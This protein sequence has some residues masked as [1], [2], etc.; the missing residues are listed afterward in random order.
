MQDFVVQPLG[1]LVGV[2]MYYLFIF[3]QIV[4]EALP[5]SSS[6]HLELIARF[7]GTTRSAVLADPL[8]ELIHVCTLGM[9]CCYF[10][11]HWLSFLR[12][13][14]SRSFAL[15]VIGALCVADGITVAF[16]LLFKFLG[17]MHI[18]LACGFFSTSL[19]LLSLHFS[20]RK[21]CDDRVVLWKAIVIGCVQGISLLPGISRLGT[22]I[23][24]GYWLGFSP[25]FALIFSCMLQ[26]PLL[27]AGVF[28]GACQIGF[29]SLMA[30]FFQPYLIAVL[31]VATLFSYP[32]FFC[33]DYSL[34]KGIAWLFGAVTAFSAVI[35]WYYGF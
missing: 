13:R 24:A 19:A 15:Q 22:T 28:K 17:T 14:L 29:S 6:G 25:R 26:L 2:L 5:V 35:A 12:Q 27:V 32:L 4:L 3:L 10:Y 11:R 1:W 21:T 30:Y 8:Y 33:W 18:S 16:Y 7:F 34:Q 20:T 31:V 23:V 9:V